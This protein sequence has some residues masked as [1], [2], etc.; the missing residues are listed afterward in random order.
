MANLN[1]RLAG[2]VVRRVQ[3]RSVSLLK[4]VDPPLGALPGAAIQSVR[5]RGKLLLFDL[6]NALVMI[7]HLMRDGRFAVVPSRQRVTRDVA[8][9]L[10]LEG[11]D[12]LRLV[13]MGPKKRA[14]LYLRRAGEVEQTEPVGGLGMEPLDDAF[15][16]ERLGALLDEAKMQ[17]KRFLSTQRYLAGIGNAYSDEILWAARLSPFAGTQTLKPEERT[18]LYA[19]IGDVLRRAVAEHRDHFGDSLPMR[20]PPVLLRVHRRKGDACPRCGAP[21]AAVYYSERETYYCPGCQTGGKVYADR[22]LSRLLK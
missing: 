17:V 22:R 1:P 14:G 3:L 2:R 21:V 11:G 5:R 13:E 15:T 8:L 7:V 18:R 6:S 12:D 10:E 4:S 19:A 20:E 9:V 16:A